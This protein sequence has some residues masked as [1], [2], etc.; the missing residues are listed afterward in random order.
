MSE[1]SDCLILF[2]KP[3]IPGRVKTRLIPAIGADAA[4]RLYRLLLEHALN[5]A[6]KLESVRK[7]LWCAPPDVEQCRDY[8]ER[9]GMVLRTQ[10][11]AD[12]GERMHHALD[13][14]LRTAQRA[15]LI[16]SDSPCYDVDYLNSAFEALRGHDAVLGPAFDGGY[17]LIGTKKSDSR[18]FRSIPWSGDRVLETTR[19][20][21]LQMGWTRQ[22]LPTRHD[23]DEVADLDHFPELSDQIFE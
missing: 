19:Q 22:E 12:L 21:L 1:Y 18:L 17:L 4:T 3:P 6:A 23:V 2:A 5:A 15:V 11:G 14:V 9:Y 10:K 20:R 7:E 13:S 8:A 16:G